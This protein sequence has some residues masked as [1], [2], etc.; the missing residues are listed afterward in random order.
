MQMSR[1]EGILRRRETLER[2]RQLLIDIQAPDANES[3]D[4][5]RQ[6]ASL[7]SQS[8]TRGLI[9]VAKRAPHLRSQCWAIFAL[10]L[11]YD[12]RALSTLIECSRPPY[13]EQVRDEA[14]EALGWFVSKK[15]PRAVAAVLSA[16][17]DPS[18]PVRWSAAF[19]L[20]YSPWNSAVLAALE[21]MTLDD[22]LPRG[23]LT[24]VS[25][26]ARESLEQVLWHRNLCQESEIE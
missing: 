13:P 6:I 1:K 23:A 25:A 9:T 8:A 4:A 11:L 14:V 21:R 15:R 26:V 18:A 19:S 20:G 24:T 3:L 16:S 22:E 7:R 5:A 2:L 10:R 17:H 12:K